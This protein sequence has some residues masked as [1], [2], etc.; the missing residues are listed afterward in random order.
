M[1]FQNLKKKLFYQSD[2]SI[3]QPV[4][5]GNQAIQANDQPG[6]YRTMVPASNGTNLS[7]QQVGSVGWAQPRPHLVKGGPFD[8]AMNPGA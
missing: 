6:L 3:R 5:L 4:E 1:G 8:G 7:N 2:A